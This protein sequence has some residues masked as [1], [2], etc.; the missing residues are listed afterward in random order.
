MAP[1]LAWDGTHDNILAADPLRSPRHS[2]RR[3]HDRDDEDQADSFDIGCRV[4]F[5]AAAHRAS[6]SPRGRHRP[7]TAR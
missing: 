1:P 4:A 2:R 3:L 6:Q 7:G 5:L